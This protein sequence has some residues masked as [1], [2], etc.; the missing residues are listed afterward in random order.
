MAGVFFRKMHNNKWRTFEVTE[1]EVEQITNDYIRTSLR[2]ME[3]CIL[4][5]ERIDD[6]EVF[7][8]CTLARS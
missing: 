5:I 8:A 7:R 4:N 3:R 2:L 6:R 1:G